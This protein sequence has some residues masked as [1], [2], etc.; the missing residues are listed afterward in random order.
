MC[1]KTTYIIF[2]AAGK[3]CY[4]QKKKVNASVTGIWELW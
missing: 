1:K 3:I 4:L 2:S